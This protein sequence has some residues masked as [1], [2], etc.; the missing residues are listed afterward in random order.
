MVHAAAVYLLACLDSGQAHE[1]L[2]K[3]EA[4]VLI[5]RYRNGNFTFTGSIF[6]GHLE[7][8]GPPEP[9]VCARLLI[10]VAEAAR[11]TMTSIVRL[12]PLQ[13]QFGVGLGIRLSTSGQRSA[14]RE[15]SNRS[16]FWV[17]VRS[18]T[19]WS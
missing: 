16:S 9:N 5:V 1:A 6:G 14:C 17:V 2:A 8:D 11:S 18:S 3:V 7:L 10:G 19:C 12:A 4:N 13:I 15:P